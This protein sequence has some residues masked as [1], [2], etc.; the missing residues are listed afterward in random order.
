MINAHLLALYCQ[1][2]IEKKSD[3]SQKG[4][5]LWFVNKNKTLRK[6]TELIE[7]NKIII[8]LENSVKV[9]QLQKMNL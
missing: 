2:R 5:T 9:I 3:P 4:N 1:L 7:G 8:Y 6:H